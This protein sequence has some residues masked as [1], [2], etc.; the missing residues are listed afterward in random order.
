MVKSCIDQILEE[1]L[2]KFVDVVPTGPDFIPHLPPERSV[3]HAVEVIP[4]SASPN[5]R[6]YSMNPAQLDQLRE[7]SN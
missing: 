1:L 3:D 5:K 4:K 6:V 2:N 7:R